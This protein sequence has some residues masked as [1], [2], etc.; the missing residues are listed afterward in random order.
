MGND[1]LTVKEAKE[2]KFETTALE[3]CDAGAMIFRL[4][5]GFRPNG[6]YNRYLCS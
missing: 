5:V 2:T 3:I 1:M 4:P 6:L